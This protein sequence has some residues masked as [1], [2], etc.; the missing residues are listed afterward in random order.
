[1]KMGIKRCIITLLGLIFT[2]ALC[3]CR[4]GGDLE[5]ITLAGSTSIQPF[6]EKL[7]EVYM[8]KWPE[9]QIN[10]QGGGSTAR[11]QAAQAGIADLGCSSRELREEEKRLW[12][13]PFAI[14]GVAVIVNPKNKVNGL[15][16]NEIRGIF[17]RKIQ[18]WKEVGGKDEAIIVVTREEG[19]GTRDAFIPLVMNKEEI[20]AEAFGARLKW[21]C[22]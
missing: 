19:L 5:T 10:V 15:N 20:C 11:I 14:D 21:V 16:L 18:N 9:G 17:S 8:E 2:Q 1:M 6:A 3:G 12:H 13:L 22:P 4:S 7:V